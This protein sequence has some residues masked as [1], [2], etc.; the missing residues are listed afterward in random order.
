MENVIL[1]AELIN[2]YFILK[3][4]MDYNEIVMKAALQNNQVMASCGESPNLSF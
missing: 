3:V 2:R 1:I 4:L